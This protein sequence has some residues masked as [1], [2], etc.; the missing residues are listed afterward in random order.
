MHFFY[1]GCHLLR[2]IYII[3][4]SRQVYVYNNSCCYC[5]C[6]NTIKCNSSTTTNE[7]VIAH[8][9]HSIKTYRSAS[10]VCRRHFTCFFKRRH[11]SRCLPIRRRVRSTFGCSAFFRLIGFV[12]VHTNTPFRKSM[13]G[14]GLC[15]CM[16]V[17]QTG[18]VE[19]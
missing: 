6:F 11:Q 17:G 10:R 4:M 8:S 13:L 5:C 15:G 2:P 14:L 12:C 3:Y 18:R 1:I 16:R 7:R 9:R 19:H